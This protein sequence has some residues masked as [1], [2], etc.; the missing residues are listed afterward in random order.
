M[1]K[2]DPSFQYDMFRFIHKPIREADKKVNRFLERFVGGAQI[3]FEDIYAKIQKLTELYVPAKTPQPGYLK[4]I[5]GLTSELDN[6]IRGVSESDLRKLIQLAVPLW[7]QTGLEVGYRTIIRLFTGKNSRTFNWFDFRYVVGE[8]SL[9][10]E[11]LGEDSWIISVPGV[12]ASAPAGNVVGLWTFE[13]N[14]RDR[15]LTRNN[16]VAHG[17]VFFYGLGPVGGSDYYLGLNGAGLVRAPNSAAYDLSDSFTIECFVRTDVSQDAVLFRKAAGGKIVEVRYR[18][19][20][21]TV[22]FS[23]HD[24]TTLYTASLVAVADLDD[25]LWRHVALIVDRDAGATRLYL[26][27]TEKTAPVAIGAMGDLT[28]VGDVF[29]GAAAFATNRLDGDLDNVRFSLSAQYNVNAVFIPVPPSTFVEYQEEQ[30][31]EFYTDVRVVDNGDLNRV[32]VRRVLNLMRPPGERLRIVYIR[33]FESFDFGKG[34]FETLVAGSTV[35]DNELVMPTG[36]VELCDVAGAAD[37][38]D[39]VIQCRVLLD[40]P[41]GGTFGIRFLIQDAQNYYLFTMDTVAAGGTFKLWKVVGGVPTQLGTD[42][43][44]AVYA[45]A[46]YILTVITDRNEILGE[47]QIKTL[48]DGNV[49]HKVIDTTFEEGTWGIETQAGVAR[50]SHVEMFTLPLDTETVKPNDVI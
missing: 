19:D 36:A 33:F 11:E 6:I 47:T 2:V 8:Q 5:V 27:G 48:V 39:V 34:N 20:T 31:D 3:Q 23:L 30:L 26:D 9:A 17:P 28:N 45:D 35:L 44:E 38:K 21:N 32:L 18:S 46:F 50:L 49:L 1:A 14:L 22:S 4:D 29:I 41:A 7:K 25:G 43:F 13:Q 12:A 40:A 37:F 15:S 24:G 42:A 10:Q 16:G